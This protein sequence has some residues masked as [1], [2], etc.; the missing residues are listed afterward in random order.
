MEKVEEY[1]KINKIEKFKLTRP[2]NGD[3]LKYLD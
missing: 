1:L 3:I 2:L